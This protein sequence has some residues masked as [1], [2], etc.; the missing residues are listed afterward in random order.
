MILLHQAVEV[1]DEVVA[2]EL[3]VLVMLAHVD[4][5]DRT[6]FLAHPAEDA[7]EFVDLVD[8]RIPVPLGV[9]AGHQAD[10]VRRTDRR[11]QAAGDTLWTPVLVLLHDVRPPP[12]RRE[13]P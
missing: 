12:P 6:D 1:V 10:A 8:D 13:G 4:R 2:A 5:L 3:G 9:L 11:A 7:A